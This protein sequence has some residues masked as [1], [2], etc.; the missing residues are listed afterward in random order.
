MNI[1]TISSDCQKELEFISHGFILCQFQEDDKLRNPV[2]K[3]D[4][5]NKHG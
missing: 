3:Q 5:G 4:R 2:F 1:S